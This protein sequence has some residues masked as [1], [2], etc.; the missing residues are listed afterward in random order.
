MAEVSPQI[1]A[2]LAAEPPAPDASAPL[3]L[4]ALRAGYLQTALAL[5]GPPMEVGSARDLLIDR[6]GAPPVPAR[7]YRPTTAGTAPLGA[8]V[9][10]HGGGW[11]MGDLDGFDHVARELCE[12]AGQTVV[13]VDYRLAP[14]HPFPAAVDDARAA[15]RFVT[16]AGAEGLGV[17]PGRVAVGGDSAGGLLAAQAALL[18]P[19]LAAAQL[20]VYPALDPLMSG[21]AY[22]DF[23]EGPGLAA[24]EMAA[25]WV[26]FRGE[27]PPEKLALPAVME[28]A[29]PAWIAIAAHDPLRDDG[30]AYAASLREAGVDAQVA[31][32]DDMTHGF[33]RW[34]GAVD[35]AHELIAWL[36]GAAR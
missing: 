18:E 28:G 27:A 32:Y 2:I 25:F 7:V 12:V 26:A 6:P 8:I 30:L 31:L 10:H 33:L 36:A 21:A 14:E 5:G 9:W 22:R 15:L 4:P 35:R 20:L 16:G 19:G 24:G 3:D 1:A 29:P 11:V 23:A 17:D 34:G 13:S